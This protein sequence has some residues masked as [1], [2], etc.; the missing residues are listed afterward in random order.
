MT[1]NPAARAIVAIRSI[2]LGPTVARIRGSDAA[3]SM[4]RVVFG[5]LWLLAGRELP[6]Q[7]DSNVVA[8]V[9]GKDITAQEIGLVR[10][11]RRRPVLPDLET[12]S[13]AGNPVG[14]L[15]ATITQAAVREYV[16][17]HRLQATDGEIREF[18]EWQEAFRAQDRVRRK[19]DLEKVEL[20][21][22]DQTRTPAER[23]RLEKRRSTLGRL[24]AH[25]QRQDASPGP[26]LD[27]LREVYAPWIEGWK[28]NKSVYHRF[29]GA[30]A[31][32]KFGPDP[33]GAIARLLRTYEQAGKW[34]IRDAALRRAFWRDQHQAPERQVHA[35]KVDFTPFWK[36]P[37]RHE[38]DQ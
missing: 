2:V 4:S 38:V 1:T 16:N 18:H 22:A 9:F 27:E 23:E 8:R 35:R 26:T 24:A 25:D 30:V 14:K 34:Q 10:D 32:T 28:F 33:V 21:L 20:C 11:A 37:I 7:G 15:T 29:A 31:D 12:P 6:A 13:P 3:R 36:K 5:V 17:R 19:E